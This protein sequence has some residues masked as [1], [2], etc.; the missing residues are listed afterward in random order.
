[1]Q[2]R[3][4]FLSYEG[5]L[6]PYL[7]GVDRVVPDAIF[8]GGCCPCRRCC[9]DPWILRFLKTGGGGPTCCC[10]CTLL[11]SSWSKKTAFGRSLIII[12]RCG[13]NRLNKTRRYKPAAPICL[14]ARTLQM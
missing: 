5:S 7:D 3:A 2:N 4:I 8:V 11:V 13:R 9:C 12:L 10:P 6:Q 14:R 1:M